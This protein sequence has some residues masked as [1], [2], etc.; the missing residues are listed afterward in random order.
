MFQVKRFR[1]WIGAMILVAMIGGILQWDAWKSRSAGI[2]PQ[3]PLKKVESAAQIKESYDTIV[4]G[5]D[6]EG[7]AAAVSAARNGLKVLLV[8][9]KD[10]DILGGLMTLGWLN[11]LD[12]NYAPQQ[13]AAS[14]KHNFLN[15]G[16]FQ[17]WYNQI[18]GTSF[19]THTAANVFYKMVSGEPNIDLLM[20]TRE[21]KPLVQAGK[22]GNA[23]IGL[24]IV[25]ADQ[26]EHSVYAKTV[27]DATQDGDIAA[28][29]GAPFTMGR[30]DIGDASSQMA[31]TLVFKLGGVTPKV[32][33]SFGKH[34]HTGSD[35]MSAW[36]F[37]EMKDYVS[38]N[39]ERVRM[40]GL[41]IGR[42]NDNTVL[43]NAMQIFG[44][45]P[46]NPESVRE[47]MEIGRKEAEHI[48]TYMKN[49]F[50]EFKRVELLG[51]APELYVRETRHLKGE[52]RLT[53]TDLMENRD[54]WD[55]IA[56]GSYEV[57][58]QST[59]YKDPGSVMMKP[60]Q[61]GVPFRCL[62]P[63]KVDG[64]LVVGRAASFDSLPHGS[65]RV[66]PLGM[67]TGE[68]AGAAAKIALD[69]GVTFRQ[70]S[71]SKDGITELRDKLMQQ[72]VEL[73]LYPFDK[74]AYM[75]HK[76]FPGLKA[77][78]SMAVTIGGYD[79]MN[80]D[81]DGKSNPQRF[82]SH[83]ANVRK[84]HPAP[85]QGD[86][87]LS[88][89]HMPTPAK[90]PLTL[91]QAALTLAMAAGLKSTREEAVAELVQRGWLKKDTIKQISDPLQLTNGDSYML[92]RD[93]VENTAG[94]KYE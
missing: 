28:M 85:F 25:S 58:I 68:A 76:A 64:L 18:E 32:W 47:G 46:L 83:M 88:I 8:D 77:A 61:Y 31:V 90:Q 87:G 2:G 42:Q 29:A 91:D 40:R 30:E 73:S 15:K 27:I 66:I 72:N 82:V 51:T 3:Q 17:E 52:Y 79:N 70:L 10:R 43:I 39:K 16:I 9:G 41:N 37:P 23:V 4:V 94:V 26:T 38:T 22:A 5:T 71:Q 1:M 81:L 45:D 20:K 60:K 6:P 69:R 74:P 21:I 53:M 93:F 67:A 50:S 78:V 80:W 48:V 19:D 59:N 13:P 33:D 35:K 11:T 49:N 55:A 24:R 36:G 62:V 12:L 86:A 14:G 54:H 75:Q 92:I 7:I 63:L 56:Y 84:V 44:V 89:R 34:P 65:A 57:D